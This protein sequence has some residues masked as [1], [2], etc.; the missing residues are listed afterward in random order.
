VP[1]YRIERVHAGMRSAISTDAAAG[2]GA[3]GRRPLVPDR[4]RPI[5]G[6]SGARSAGRRPEPGNVGLRRSGCCPF[7]RVPQRRL[8]PEPT[9]GTC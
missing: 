1:G 6:R 2:P 5:R 3:G 4:M 7:R 9:W 8:G